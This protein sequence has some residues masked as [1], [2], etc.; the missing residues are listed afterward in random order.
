ME[1]E[2]TKELGGMLLGF[3]KIKKIESDRHML[4]MR[5][6]IKI[7]PM[8]DEVH[9]L[10][11]EEIYDMYELLCKNTE[12]LEE[13]VLELILYYGIKTIYNQMGDEGSNNNC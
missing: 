6:G 9:F 5:R 3:E 7:Y 4:Y 12:M 2:I 11:R 8:Y 10:L 13:E 1:N